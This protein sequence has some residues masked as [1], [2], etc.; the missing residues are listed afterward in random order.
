LSIYRLVK[1]DFPHFRQA[2]IFSAKNTGGVFAVKLAD[3]FKP[4]QLKYIC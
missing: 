3:N 4:N 1:R 2:Q